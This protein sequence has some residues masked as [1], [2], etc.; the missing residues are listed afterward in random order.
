MGDPARLG[1]RR[2]GPGALQAV[3][4]LL[5]GRVRASRLAQVEQGGGEAALSSQQARVP[6]LKGIV[7]RLKCLILKNPP[8]VVLRYSSDFDTFNFQ[9][10]TSE[11]IQ[12]E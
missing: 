12:S 6:V 5:Q 4:E 2:T 10:K 11:V 8:F 1:G 3:L 7:S 9:K